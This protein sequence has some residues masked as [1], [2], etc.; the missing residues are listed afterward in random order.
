MY[1]PVKSSSKELAREKIKEQKK[2]Q[3]CILL[4]NKFRNKFNVV[5]TTEAKVDQM[6]IS[7]VGNLLSTKD[8]S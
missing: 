3:L 5:P 4:V 6:I 8:A 7:E 1:S 2:Q